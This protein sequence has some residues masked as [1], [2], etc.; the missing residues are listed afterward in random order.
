MSGRVLDFT[1]VSYI[2][3]QLFFSFHRA[4]CAL[5]GWCSFGSKATWQDSD[6]VETCRKD[7]SVTSWRLNQPIWKICVKLEILPRW[8]WKIF[9]L[10]PPRSFFFNTLENYPPKRY[11]LLNSSVVF[12]F[13]FQTIGVFWWSF[14]NKT[15]QGTITYP[16]SKAPVTINDFP[17]FPFAGIGTRSFP[18]R[19]IGLGFWLVLWTNQLRIP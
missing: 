1:I 14:S 9:E 11:C 6:D 8:T 3:P 10:P 16:F 7:K 12:T 5:A 15:L 4:V 2:F 13:P 17:N 19:V 18:W